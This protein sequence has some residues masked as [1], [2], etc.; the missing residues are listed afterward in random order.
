MY[1]K[2]DLKEYFSE[3]DKLLAEAS[4]PGPVVTLSREFGCEVIPIAQNLVTRLNL[5]KNPT[6]N[7]TQPRWQ[8]ISKEILNESAK[9]LQRQPHEVQ[10]AFTPNEK[11]N[12]EEMISSLSQESISLNKINETIKDIILTYSKKGHVII[13]GRGGVSVA[14]E[15]ERS[16]H[17]RVHAPLSYR[18]ENLIKSKN[19]S[20]QEAEKMANENDSRRELFI[21]K[22]TGKK[23]HPSIFDASLNRSTLSADD[24]VKVIMDLMEY[25]DLID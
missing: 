19:L 10:R 20:A 21:G 16:L 6:K 3:K 15:I 25:K 12:L 17:I 9:I 22:L 4:Q 1:M 13:V 11:S 18:I 24:I 7:T 8:W 23:F 2:I 14:K 5:S